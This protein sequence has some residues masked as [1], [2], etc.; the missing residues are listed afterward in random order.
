VTVPRGCDR[1]E[2]LFDCRDSSDGGSGVELGVVAVL[3]DLVVLLVLTVST[4]ECLSCETL[5]L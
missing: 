4:D 3:V 2:L 5:A 1:R